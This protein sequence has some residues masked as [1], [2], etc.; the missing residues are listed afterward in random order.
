[1]RQDRIQL[2]STYLPVVAKA[3]ALDASGR[4]YLAGTTSAPITTTYDAVQPLPAAADGNAFFMQLAPNAA[5]L[6]YSTYLG[7]QSGTAASALAIDP[8][9]YVYVGGSANAAAQLSDNAECP[10]RGRT[11]QRVYREAHD[12]SRGLPDTR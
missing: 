1:M 4:I 10:A 5:S 8:A 11:R 9:G 7:D 6:L 12:R 2:F 3:L